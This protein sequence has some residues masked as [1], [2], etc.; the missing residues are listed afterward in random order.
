MNYSR[1]RFHSSPQLWKGLCDLAKVKNNCC[2]LGYFTGDGMKLLSW[3]RLW[4]PT[5]FLWMCFSCSPVPD[6]WVREYYS[7]RG[8]RHCLNQIYHVKKEETETP[9]YC[10]T[11]WAHWFILFLKIKLFFIAS[12]IV[13]VYQI[14]LWLSF[15]STGFWTVCLEL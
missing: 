13:H 15:Q 2:G 12:I 6:K 8:H 11:I 14:M 10:K 7:W 4:W 1:E 9:K 3:S 5:S